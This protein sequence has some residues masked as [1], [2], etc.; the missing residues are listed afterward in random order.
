MKLSVKE[1]KKLDEFI[2]SVRK[3]INDEQNSDPLIHRGAQFLDR[4]LDRL[5]FGNGF[6]TQ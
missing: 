2:D 6:A 4:L 3:R 1:T 5:L